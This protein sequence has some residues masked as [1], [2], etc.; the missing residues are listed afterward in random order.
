MCGYPFAEGVVVVVV[1]VLTQAHAQ[2]QAMACLCLKMTLEQH[3]YWSS[4]VFVWDECNCACVWFRVRVVSCTF[5]LI[6]RRLQMTRFAKYQRVSALV[7]QN[8]HTD[9][10]PHHNRKYSAGNRNTTHTKSARSETPS[11]LVFFF[12]VI[13]VLLEW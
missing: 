8:T 4:C 10:H 13:L 7:H 9:Q 5:M 3:R 11:V 6:I 2:A 12:P 1:V